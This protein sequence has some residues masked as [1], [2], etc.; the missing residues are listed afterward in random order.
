[1]TPTDATHEIQELD[2]HEVSLVDAPANKRKFLAVKS[3]EKVM[4]A[5]KQLTDDGDGG[6]TTVAKAFDAGRKKK[7]KSALSGAVSSLSKLLEGIEAAEDEASF[8]KTI[9][10]VAS[11]LGKLGGG[12]SSESAS[13]TEKAEPAVEPEVETPPTEPDPVEETI[14]LAALKAIVDASDEREQTRKAAKLEKSATER[15]ERHTALTSD[16]KSLT[17]VVHTMVDIVKS[18][19]SGARP[20]S[21]AVS[22]GETSPDRQSVSKLWKLDMAAEDTPDNERF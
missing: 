7:F 11:S 18:N 4:P 1:M 10:G 8:S 9:A 21:Q 20:V 3:E 22:S 19:P 6:L 17:R 5:G 16:L 13:A 14:S 2:V 12:G 15:T